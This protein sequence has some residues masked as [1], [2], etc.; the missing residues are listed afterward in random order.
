[1]VLRQLY[2]L[3]RSNLGYHYTDMQGRLLPM[4][5]IIAVLFFQASQAESPSPEP[6]AVVGEIKLRKLNVFDLSNEEEN[7]WLYRLANRLHIVTRDRVI[8]GQLLFEPGEQY[9]QRLFEETER[10]LRRNRY[11]Y[12]A[13][14]ET[15]LR[16]DGVVDVVVVTKDV[17]TLGPDLSLSRKGGENKSQIGIEESNSFEFSD[18]HLGHSWVSMYLQIA[19]NSDGETSQFSLVRPFYALDARWSAG[20]RLSNNDGRDALYVLLVSRWSI[21]EQ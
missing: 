13:N 17:W 18:R 2:D 9:D 6:E 5:M 4:A 11:L 20:G 15:T 14:I 10:I 3:N 16:K 21:I 8:R 12:D 19:D 1:M 7:N